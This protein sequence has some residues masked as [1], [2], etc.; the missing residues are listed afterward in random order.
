M[1]IDATEMTITRALTELK[2]LDKR[3][4]K[5]IDS[6]VFVEHQGKFYEPSAEVRRAQAVYQSINDLINRRRAIK[7]QIIASNAQTT[8]TICGQT[9]S[10]AEAIEMKSSIKH[11]QHLLRNMRSQYGQTSRNIETINAQVR[12]DLESKTHR[13]GSGNEREESKIDM[14]DF[15]SKYMDMHGVKLFDPL[16][17]SSRIDELE[18]KITGF[19]SEV[20]YILS[21]KN[22]VTKITV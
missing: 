15:S 1:S 10:M 6:A 22:A 19:E 9:M 3:I 4:Q 2:T 14:I 13:G 11:Y 5:N 21:E 7:S 12:R 17:V 16:K 8:V 20:D 18:A